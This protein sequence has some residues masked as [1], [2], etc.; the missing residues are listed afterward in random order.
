LVSAHCGRFVRRQ[1]ALSPA[2]IRFGVRA[3]FAG[4]AV[5]AAF[6]GS[7]RYRGASSR[8]R[9]AASLRAFALE[10]VAALAALERL[11]RSMTAVAFLEH[12]DVLIEIEHSRSSGLPAPTRATPR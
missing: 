6:H 1:I 3:L 9:R 7:A 8:E 12:P 2:H 11:L 4:L 10:Q 5:F